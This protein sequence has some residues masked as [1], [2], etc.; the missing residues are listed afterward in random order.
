MVDLLFTFTYSANLLIFIALFL[1]CCGWTYYSF[2]KKP[3]LLIIPPL[4]IQALL[5]VIFVRIASLNTD[6]VEHLHCAWLVGQGLVPFRDFWQHHSP[7]LWALLAPLLKMA[8]PSAGILDI[9]RFFSLGVS[10]LSVLVGWRI[11]RKVWRQDAHL[12]TYLLMIFSVSIGAEFFLLRPDIFMTLCLLTGIYVSLSIPRGGSLV[13]FSAGVFFA[14]AMSFIFKQ[15]GMVLLPLIVLCIYK[16]RGALCRGLLAY[17]AGL[18]IGFLP[19][20]VYL[21]RNHI[22]KD[23]VEWV[24]LSN[25][26]RV[27]I[28]V[29]FPLGVLLVG[30]WG[31]WRLYRRVR[32]GGEASSLVFLIAFLL[33]SASSF[34]GCMYPAGGY[35]LQ[36]WLVLCSV[37]AS[38]GIFFVIADTVGA[39]FKKTL[40]LA[41]VFALLIGPPLIFTIAQRENGFARDKEVIAGLIKYTRGDTC[42]AFL[43]LHPIFSHDATRMYSTWQYVLSDQFR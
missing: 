25:R 23:F 17:A 16:R 40:A 38:G 27:V 12:P 24:I 33:S 4:V 43:P 26:E 7:L 20:S 21:V 3:S 28:A 2:K 39:F 36:F 13:V 37:V 9:S 34:T 29:L 31:A 8:K 35:Y 5:L 18:G 11:A 41:T 22:V 15:Y 1:G 14:L 30:G 32:S 19:L 10:A 42:V 6:E